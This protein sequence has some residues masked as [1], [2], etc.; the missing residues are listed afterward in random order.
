MAAYTINSLEPTKTILVLEKNNKTLSDYRAKG[1]DSILN[2]FSA[3][4]DTD[5]TNSSLSTDNKTVWVGEG[6]GGGT[7]HFGLQYI[8]HPD[9]INKNH[10]DLLTIINNMATITNAQR[11]SYATA[12]SPNTAWYNLK[13]S[14]ESDTSILTQ[15]NKIYCDNLSTGS[16]IL[17]GELIE[18][19]S[20]IEIKYNVTVN[21]I[22]I[23]GGAVTQVETSDGNYTATNYILAAGAIQSPVILLKSGISTGTKLYDHAGYTLL[24]KKQT[25]STTTNTSVDGYTDAELTSLGLTK[26]T[27]TGGGSNDL[28]V[29]N[30][31]GVGDNITAIFRH[32]KLSTADV[33]NAKAGTQPT[34]SVTLGEGVYYVYDMGTYWSG[35]SGGHPGGDVIRSRLGTSYDL[36]S[37]LTG[38]HGQAYSRLFTGGAKLLGVQEITTTTTTTS[39]VS[40]LGFGNIVGH[41]Q[42][43]DTGM[44]WQ[45]YYS[46]VP[47]LPSKLIVTHAQGVH[48][49]GS[50]SI[51]LDGND[52]PVVTLNH[53]GSGGFKTLTL[54]YL[55]EAYQKNHAI[56]TN[57]GYVLDSNFT[58]NTTYIENAVNSIYHYQGGTSDVLDNNN[59]V[60]GVSNLYVGDSSALKDPWP[61]STSVPSMA[62]GYKVANYIYNINQ[63][64]VPFIY[65]D[66]VID[67]L[68]KKSL[69]AAYTSKLYVT[70]QETPILSNIQTK[71][72]F[73]SPITNMP[74]NLLDWSTTS[75]AVTG[76]GTYK[77]LDY[78]NGETLP[79]SFTYIRKYE[80]IPM[81]VVAGTNNRSWKPTESTFQEKFNNVILG[82]P[83]F[84]YILSTDI[85]NYETILSSSSAFKPI[86]NN[87]V[88]TFLGNS[89]PQSNTVLKL[90]E[91]YVY[92]GEMGAVGSVKL[93]DFDD[94]ILGDSTIAQ[95][96]Q[97]LA[98]D[99][100][101]GVWKEGSISM[102]YMPI[103]KINDFLEVNTTGVINL[104]PIIY[105]S[106]TTSYKPGKINRILDNYNDVSISSPVTTNYGVIY[107][108]NEWGA[109]PVQTPPLTSIVDLPDVD[110]SAN[111]LTNNQGLLY[112]T[113]FS[114]FGRGNIQLPIPNLDYFND[115][116]TAG[117]PD[118]FRL[119]WNATDLE[120]N[121]TEVGDVVNNL[122]DI[123]DVDTSNLQDETPQWSQ[124]LKLEP[125]QKQANANFGN[126]VAI[127]ISYALVGSYV[128]D[129]G[130]DVD[131]GAAYLF[132]HNSF[133]PTDWGQ[134]SKLYPLSANAGMKFGSSVKINS[135]FAMVTAPYH[136]YVD[137]NTYIQAGS[138]Y[139]FNHN[140][141]TGYYGVQNGIIWN[142]SSI[143]RPTTK[144]S[145]DTFGSSID[146][147]GNYL[148]VGAI[149]K[150]ATSNKGKAYMFYYENGNWVEK[151][152]LTADDGVNGD[153]FG[154]SVATN[155]EYAFV[156][157]PN[158]DSNKG[159]VY[160]FKK[161]HLGNDNWGLLKKIQ[162]TYI[163]PNDYFGTAIAVNNHNAFISSPG[164]TDT[165]GAV[166]YFSERLDV[167]GVDV[168]GEWKENHKMTASD[169]ENNN[170]F[171]ISLAVSNTIAVVG[172]SLQDISGNVDSGA[173]YIF[174]NTGEGYWEEAEKITAA[175]IEAGD[176]FGISV[177]VHYKTVTVGAWKEDDPNNGGS[178]YMYHL[179]EQS[180]GT[181]ILLFDVQTS[182]W[183][184][185]VITSSGAGIFVTRLNHLSDVDLSNNDYPVTATST[186]MYDSASKVW[187]PK[188]FEPTLSSIN[189]I[190]LIDTTGAQADN[191]LQYDGTSFKPAT[192][193]T[194]ITSL[195]DIG[196]IV[197]G[198]TTTNIA[199]E[200]G[201][202]LVYNDASGG[203]VNSNIG[204]GLADGVETGTDKV[205]TL[206]D[207]ES[208]SLF[209]NTVDHIFYNKIDTGW[210][211]MMLEKNPL[212]FGKPTLSFQDWEVKVTGTTKIEIS[213]TIPKQFPT[214]LEAEDTDDNIGGIYYLPSIYNIYFELAHQTSPFD[215]FA[216]VLIGGRDKGQTLSQATGSNKLTS[217]IILYSGSGTDNVYNEGGI[218][219]YKW[220]N[221]STGNTRKFRIWADNK[222]PGSN[223]YKVFENITF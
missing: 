46:T 28:S 159:K 142:E 160:L 53:L 49:S 146:M 83:N 215:D 219:V 223:I 27:I 71:Q 98:Y 217:K 107:K 114:S 119:N 199:L 136:S 150:D 187:L 99:T 104:D 36:T 179:P 10:S 109:H 73:A 193:Q 115:V 178:M 206:V 9:V 128:R 95:N 45:T 180:T 8:D 209:Y 41:L 59:Q 222:T 198:N 151:K 189:D 68:L 65:N 30:Q 120:W 154:Y 143:I 204:G 103:Q 5:F 210:L 132:K 6:L 108:N 75:T 112:D 1:Y 194:P 39:D 155:Q 58:I 144:T 94:V 100:I 208:G 26:Y 111:L 131:I 117:V 168:A 47:A 81:S 221:I 152:I 4:N 60:L 171:G 101:T 169:G 110:I 202:G 161:N 138:V 134:I 145:Y 56:L 55:L 67:M 149:E 188:D 7:L 29:I 220:Y 156:G 166:Y 38:Q 82:K 14:L 22:A 207:M 25:S 61:G 50:G 200:N 85:T 21:K 127:D 54:A 192:F 186:L 70:G 64:T 48:I 35:G 123:R 135:S 63:P 175:D 34:G 116:N 31:G 102:P 72:I 86:I 140:S 52:N 176:E 163:A 96:T 69:G 214:I 89:V 90:K 167:W 201:H 84:S 196:D 129:T 57:A 190:P 44:N 87:G 172:S 158:H 177:A 182:R 20:N 126:S 213:W 16:R 51:S 191:I 23:S 19:K 91:I 80:N 212:I 77:T 195:G 106:A 13:Q 164:T 62:M 66:E 15:N 162:P 40:D 93:N 18:N 141:T 197:I 32:T 218:N 118:D 211:Q 153:E 183:K 76:G 137:G 33:T 203:W 79:E 42:T 139:V 12:N 147:S 78:V 133:D 113:L 74:S 43:R 181:R 122:L 173:A 125:I 105:Q 130:V 165:S 97:P 205:N 174:Y 17:I 37:V 216:S 170:K 157:A 124:V 24:Y 184:V 2:W 88:L 11:Y 185:G 92:D 3:Q 148:I 121:F